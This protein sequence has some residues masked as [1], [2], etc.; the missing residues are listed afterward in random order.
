[1]QSSL[2]GGPTP[3]GSLRHIQV[4]REGQTITDF[5]FYDLLIE[6][7]KSKD[8][9]LQPGDVIYF[10]PVGP[11]VAI[12]G[13]VNTPAIYEMRDHSTLNELIEIAGGLSTV[14]DTSRITIDRF[15]GHQSR[16]TLEF[17]YDDQ[18][19]A[20]TLS[21]GDIVR[22]YPSSRVS[23]TRLLCAAT[24]PIPDAIPGSRGCGYA[25]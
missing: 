3:Q 11:L 21:D 5:D 16:Q 4:R 22:S 18:S 15:V 25:I 6:G 14:A 7:N 19:R 8:I 24:S 1:M 12:A 20:T 9:R 13:S 10:S 23:K 2:L 17:P